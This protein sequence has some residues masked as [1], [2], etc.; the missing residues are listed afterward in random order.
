MALSSAQRLA[1]QCKQGRAPF[2]IQMKLIGPDG[3]ELPWDGQTSGELLVRGPWIVR[4]YFP[5]SPALQDGWFATGDMA[6][7]D[8]EGYMQI[9]DRSKDV[10]KSGGEWISSIE[11]EH[12]ALSHPAVAGAACIAVR[13]PKWDERPLLVVVCKAG[14]T[15]TARRTAGPLRPASLP[16]GR[17]RTTWCSWT[18]SR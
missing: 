14:A 8:P 6:T 2:P 16:A 12:I 7:I 3:R 5:G 15:V 11:L 17:F 18:R 13:H 4:E 10:I 1:V 9:T